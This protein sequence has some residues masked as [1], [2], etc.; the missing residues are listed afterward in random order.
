[1]P[2]RRVQ[3]VYPSQL[4]DQ[5]ILFQLIQTFGVVTSILKADVTEGGGWLLIE[6]RGDEAIVAQALDWLRQIGIE[7]QE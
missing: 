3:L 5:P 4:V 7:V 1:M 2:G 6:M